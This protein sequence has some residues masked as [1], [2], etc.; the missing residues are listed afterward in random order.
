MVEEKLEGGEVTRVKQE[1]PSSGEVVD[2]LAALQK[3]VAAAKTAR[4]ESVDED[5][6]VCRG[7]RR[8]AR[9]Q[10]E[11]QEGSG[12]EERREEDT[13][14][15]VRREED[16][17]QEERQEGLLTGTRSVAQVPRRRT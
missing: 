7:G 4:G 15:E 6:V 8:E 16:H 11:H 14:Q 5:D 13:G 1:K 12:E 9:R 2:L 17:G 10:E 3:S